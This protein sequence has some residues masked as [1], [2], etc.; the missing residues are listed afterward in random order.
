MVFVYWCQ[1]SNGFQIIFDDGIWIRF[2][3]AKQFTQYKNRAEAEGDIFI[4][5]ELFIYREWN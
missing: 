5:R 4:Y 2:G 1:T 3:T